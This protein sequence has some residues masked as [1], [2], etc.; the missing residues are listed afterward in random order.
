MLRGHVAL[1]ERAVREVRAAQHETCEE[2][3]SPIPE[4]LYQGDD[5]LSNILVM[6]IWAPLITFTRW[7]CSQQSLLSAGGLLQ[8][9]L[10]AG[11]RG[12]QI[13]ITKGMYSQ[14]W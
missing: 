14:I 4:T 3:H 9:H 6:L 5:A 12:S 8:L 2:S 1:L 11:I 13:S 10:V 7:S